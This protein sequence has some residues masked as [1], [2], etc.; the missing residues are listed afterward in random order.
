MRAA[1][2][3]DLNDFR[4]LGKTLNDLDVR[5]ARNKKVEPY[6]VVSSLLLEIKTCGRNR[7]FL[8]NPVDRGEGLV[9]IRNHECIAIRS[10]A[11]NPVL[12]KGEEV[13]REQTHRSCEQGHEIN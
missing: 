11:L 3:F 6:L 12:D 1:A 9:K 2:R 4:Y 8:Q 7:A 5:L 13:Q 10:P